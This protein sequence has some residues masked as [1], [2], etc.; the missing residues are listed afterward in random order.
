MIQNYK[1][2]KFLKDNLM[3]LLDNTKLIVNYLTQMKQ[4]AREQIEKEK[5]LPVLPNNAQD[6]VFGF[7][8]E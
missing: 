2:D 3:G 7:D 6:V 5:R 8:N 1:S 4:E